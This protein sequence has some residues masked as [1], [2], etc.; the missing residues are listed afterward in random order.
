[1]AEN[2]R[3]GISIHVPRAGYDDN[4][5]ARLGQAVY[6]YPRTPCGVRLESLYTSGATIIFLST[7]P[8]R[9]TTYLLGNKIYIGAIS[10]HVPRAGYDPSRKT[11]AARQRNFYPRTPCGVR[12][13]G[14]SCRV[15]WCSI[16]IHVPRAGYDA[17]ERYVPPSE[18][19]SIHVPRAG[20]D[21]NT[22]S[23]SAR[24]RT[25]LSTYPVRGTTCQAARQR[26]P[27]RYFYPRT[28][29]GVRLNGNINMGSSIIFLST[30]PV[31]GTT[32]RDVALMMS[33]LNFYPRTPCGVRQRRL[34]RLERGVVFL[35]TYPVRGTTVELPLRRQLLQHFYPRTPCGVRLDS[36][37]LDEKGQ[38]FLSTYPV[39]GT[40]RGCCSPCPGARHFYP[41]TPC[42]VRRG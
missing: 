4:G 33:L 35:S 34:L 6:F 5:P 10:I 25:F 37:E 28:P 15:S 16:S 26:S 17:A 22:T 12:R 24:P 38:I 41:R 42:G 8:V 31:R 14:Q 32:A 21:M 13:S 23:S 9:G 2:H 11:G 40:T 36:I 20:Y 29:C 30:Y 7:Y 18:S 1:M 39:R 19:I 3:L 27:C